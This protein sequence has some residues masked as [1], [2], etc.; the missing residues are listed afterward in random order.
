MY[1]NLVLLISVFCLSLSLALGGQ[2]F[3]VSAAYWDTK[4]EDYGYGLNLKYQHS[5]GTLSNLFGEVRVSYFTGF[6][7]YDDDF[8]LKVMPVEA[9]LIYA[10]ASDPLVVYAGGGLGYY[11]YDLDYGDCEVDNEFGYYGVA[12]ATVGIARNV[13]FFAEIKYTHTEISG[14]GETTITQIGNVIIISSYG[15]DS[16]LSGIG[17]NLGVKWNW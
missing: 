8:D 16:D 4:D 12:G 11:I 17:A 15:V 3:G 2:G 13:D 5:L 1:K 7:K 14:S 10:I 9:G 6:D